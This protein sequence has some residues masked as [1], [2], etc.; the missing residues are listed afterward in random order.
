MTEEADD[1]RW[2]EEVARRRAAG[3]DLEFSPAA[4]AAATSSDPA[5]SAL[6]AFL[7]Q[8]VA[9]GD[10]V[11][12]DAYRCSVPDCRRVLGVEGAP[13]VLCPH[14]KTDYQLEG[15]APEPEIFYRLAGALSR[16]IR[17]MIVVHGMNSRAA[18]QE[19]FSWRIANRLRYSAPVL[20]YKYGWAT[21][22][23]LVRPMHRRIAK[24]L[25]RRMQIAIA[26]AAAADKPERPDVIAHSF[27]T[28]LLQMVLEDPEF[29]DVRLGRVITAGSIIRPDFD[30][31]AMLE[32]D[33]IEAILNHAGSRDRPVLFAQFAIPGTGP[34]GRKG[35]VDAAALNV[36]AVGFG[37]SDFFEPANLQAFVADGG[38]WD[39]FLTRPVDQFA[40]DGIFRPKAWKPASLLLRGPARM[41][42]TALFL[43]VAPFSWLRRWIDP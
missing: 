27:G 1:L 34:S 26:E 29:A 7:E 41:I 11:R 17:W 22:D 20:I 4:F 3:A 31:T 12:I 39:D 15:I 28:R 37:H 38:L 35:F 24:R 19:E 32:G 8:L 13:Y 42:G 10:A 16:D 6:A 33:R 14:C 21:I 5:D 43:I 40:P 25:G 36:R 23:V 18:W 2:R 30:W 9:A